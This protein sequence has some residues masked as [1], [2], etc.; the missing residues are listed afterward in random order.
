[1]AEVAL[2]RSFPRGV[3]I[4]A[5]DHSG[6]DVLRQHFP[7]RHRPVAGDAF[8]PRLAMVAVIEKK[9][10]AAPGTP[11]PT[12][13]SRPIPESWPIPEFAQYLS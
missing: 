1:M 4:H 10:T 8:N 13:S 3:T 9:Q 12:Q 11:A 6:G 2:R 7:V 5:P